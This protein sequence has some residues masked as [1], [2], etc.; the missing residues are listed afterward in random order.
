MMKGMGI[1]AEGKTISVPQNLL[2]SEP[3]DV[4]LA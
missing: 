3:V 2:Q 1:W 4:P